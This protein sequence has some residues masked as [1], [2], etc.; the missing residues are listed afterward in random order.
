LDREGGVGELTAFRTEEDED[1]DRTGGCMESLGGTT[2]NDVDVGDTRS[3]STII[4]S[5]PSS[6]WVPNISSSLT[7]VPIINISGVSVIITGIVLDVL[8]V[9]CGNGWH[10]ELFLS[11]IALL[12]VITGD[13]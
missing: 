12:I 6:T 8:E 13:D 10:S 9:F 11:S 2:A 3:S 1:G 5:I 4:P 7:S